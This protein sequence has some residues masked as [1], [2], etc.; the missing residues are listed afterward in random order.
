MQGYKRRMLIAPV[1]LLAL[2]A[3]A[4][5]SG[6]GGGRD[7]TPA[8]AATTAAPSP[9]ITK[10]SG[11]VILAT[12]TST[13]DS[14]LLDELI[15]RFEDEYGYNVTVIA[16]GSGQAIAQ[17]SRG[18]ADVVLAHSPTAE[19][20][21]V[22]EGDGIERARVMHNDF[23]IVGP[24]ADPSGV[25]AATT[26]DEAMAAIFT[27]A[28]GFISR[29][30]DSGTHALEKKLWTDA[31]LTPFAESWY[32]ESGQGMGATLQIANQ[33]RAYTI[34]DRGT[35]LAQRE[36]LDLPIVFEG[37]E[38]L[39]NVYHVIVV[40]PEK[41]PDVNAAGA[42]AFAAFLLRGDVQA[43]IGEFGAETYGQALFTP[44]E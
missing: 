27:G 25:K 19:Q 31:A 10:A 9:A 5:G 3:W 23:I 41:H 26:A 30:D 6:D 32:K 15:P 21:M 39:F 33:E 17:A 18:D 44:N 20:E 12:T 42:R 34:T 14:G 4:C 43:L 35:W 28:A 37:E 36:T 38:A 16:V 2:L 24:E 29:G 40:N 1:L 22:D 11:T 8:A 13:Q 7:G